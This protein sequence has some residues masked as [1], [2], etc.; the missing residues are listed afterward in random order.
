MLSYN[1]FLL[2]DF[3]LS[4]C[5]LLIFKKIKVLVLVAFHMQSASDKTNKVI[6]EIF[7]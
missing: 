6:N 5:F 4:L 3:V 2:F 7:N 1:C